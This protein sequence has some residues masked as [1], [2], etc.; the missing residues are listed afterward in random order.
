MAL[1]LASLLCT[2]IIN[3][4]SKRDVHGSRNMFVSE[5]CCRALGRAGTGCWCDAC[6]HLKRDFRK[7]VYFYLQITGL[8][9][10]EFSSFSQ[11]DAQFQ[12]S[13]CIWNIP[14]TLFHVFILHLIVPHQHKPPNLLQLF[15]LLKCYWISA[16]SLFSFSFVQVLRDVQDWM[17]TRSFQLSDLRL[18]SLQ[19]TRDHWGAP[20]TTAHLVFRITHNIPVVLD[21]SPLW[22]HSLIQY[23]YP[24]LNK[25]VKSNRYQALENGFNG[26][27]MKRGE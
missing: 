4:V 7:A 21:R 26:F 3:V 14:I 15:S 22:S 11:G 27:W 25:T 12:S 9:S 8:R 16:I 23:S 10:T 5:S 13:I 17:E 18:T 19:R 6:K 1:K 2:C 24:I 20:R